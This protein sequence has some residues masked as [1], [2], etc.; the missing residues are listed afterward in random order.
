MTPSAAH[1]TA[2][3]QPNPTAIGLF[4]AFVALTL[5]ITYWVLAARKPP[6]STSQPPV[7]SALG[8]KV[9]RWRVTT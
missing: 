3:G 5:G 4:F 6:A 9:S 1:Q 2:L 8:K 7:V